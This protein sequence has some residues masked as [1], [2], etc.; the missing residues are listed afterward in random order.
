MSDE[1]DQLRAR[2]DELERRVRVLFEQTGTADWEAEAREAPAVSNEVRALLASGEQ[3]KAV[4]RYMQETGATLG[5]AAA[6]LGEIEKEL[7]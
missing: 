5:Q 7:S 1:I 3:K 2:V 6:A 4:E